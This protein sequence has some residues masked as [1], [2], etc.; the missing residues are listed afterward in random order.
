[1][2]TIEKDFNVI[3]LLKDSVFYPASGIDGKGIEFLIHKSKSFIQVDYSVSIREVRTAMENDFKGVGYK[4][5]RLTQIGKEEIIQPYNPILNEHE[6][7]KIN[8]N[9]NIKERYELN[10]FS[11]FMLQ[12]IYE[13]ERGTEFSLLHVG[14]EACSVFNSL[15]VKNNINP[16]AVVIINP[17]EGYGDNW[18][19]FTDPDFKFY[20]PEGSK[21]F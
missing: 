3:D 7:S 5:K 15:Y 4:L 21:F 6:Q 19:K 1:M 17:S 11:S 8:E 12:A 9:S 14:A 18:T 13:N 20:K 2:I 16:K 10:N